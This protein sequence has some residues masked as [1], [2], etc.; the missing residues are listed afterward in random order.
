VV[1]PIAPCTKSRG[2][3]DDGGGP[4]RY[5]VDAAAREGSVVPEP[6]PTDIETVVVGAGQAGLA[7]SH[8]LARRALPHVVLDANSRVGDAWRRRWDSLRLFTPARYDGLPGLP[9]PGRASSYP[10]KDEMADYLEQYAAHFDLPIHGDVAVNTVRPVG[11]RYAVRYAGSS[12]TADNVVVATGSHHHPRIP[13]FAAD[14]ADDIV[15]LHSTQY[16]RPG[17]IPEGDVLVVG[18]ANSGAEIAMDLSGTHHVLLSGRHPGEEPTRA[19]SVPD[20]LL[21]PLIWFMASKVLTVGNPIGRKMRDHLLHPPRGI[22]L[23]RVRRKELE[24]AGV[25]AVPRTDRVDAGLPV[26][27]DGQVHDVAAVIWCTGFVPDFGWIEEDVF[28]DDGYPDH[29]RGVVGS[30][31][32]LYFMGLPFQYALSSALVGGVAR[33]AE[34]VVRHIAQSRTRAIADRAGAAQT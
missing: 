29:R 28:G 3:P 31:P 2:T 23:G 20:R 25:V 19:G 26:T 13:D 17:Q 8:H 15:Q 34:F 32:G 30:A 7:A 9:F 4:L 12:I 14:L 5:V 10:T 33:D 16:R 18:A 22:P 1:F 21:T 6:I 24:A 11:G 27:D